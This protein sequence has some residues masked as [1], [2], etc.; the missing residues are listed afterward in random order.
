[1]TDATARFIASST[2]ALLAESLTLPTDV[3][4]VRLQVNT[5]GTYSGMIDCGYKT[6][7]DEGIRGLWKGL[8]P[9][10]FRQVCYTSLSMVLYEP[11]RDFVTFGASDP[12]FLQ[13]LLAGGTAGGIS[14]AIFNPT[15]VLKTQ[16][17]TAQ[18]GTVTIGGIVKRVYDKDGIGG[19]W[20]GVKPNVVRTFLVN[21]AELGTYDQAKFIMSQHWG[22]GFFTHLGASGIAGF[23]SACISTPVDVAKTRM[24]NN[25]G[26]SGTQPGMISTI[27]DIGR[28]AGVRGLYAGF[29]PICTRKLLWCSAF[30][31]SYEHIL[32][33][34]EVLS[35]E[36]TF[37]A[38][39]LIFFALYLLWVILLGI[40]RKT[41]GQTS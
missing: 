7:R 3:I 25:A 19:F 24:M 31:A 32:P 34:A 22:D 20:A 33:L 21:A 38:N 39:H 29:V 1:M 14:I 26:K 11:I 37:S 5:I 10:V 27:L 2:G 6:Y 36:I 17:Q 30:F 35:T 28:T 13:R 9:A 4:K 40:F 16:L 12:N 15:E 8:Y 18:G 23:T 41:K